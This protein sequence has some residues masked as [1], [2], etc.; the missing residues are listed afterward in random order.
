MPRTST[1]SSS[2]PE[3][4]PLGAPRG[5]A[6]LRE[7]LRA[8]GVV[9]SK[10]W[11]QSFLVDPF[12]ADM[13]TA[14]LEATAG[15]PI[16]EIGGGLGILTEAILRRG[17]GPITVVERDP[18]LARHLRE[19]ARGAFTVQLADALEVEFGGVRTVVGN[20]PFSVAAPILTRLFEA[21][22][23]RIVVL[24]QKEVGERYTAPAGGRRYGRP[25]IQAAL[26]GRAERFA[27]VPRSAFEPTPKVDGIL[28]R[29]SGRPGPLPVPSVTRFEAEVRQLF[30]SR[31]KQLGNL[32][33][34]LA[35]GTEG[36][37]RLADRAGWPEGWARRRPEELPP[38]SYFAL[39][40]ARA[41]PE[42][43]ASSEQ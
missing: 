38:E 32:L 22:V 14:L 9:P 30:A 27:T 39:S 13:E 20:L 4:A 36:A 19:M 42:E 37:R 34:A 18:R 33:P 23:G 40:R 8:L 5:A 28:V 43:P 16:V 1:G 25:A 11:G 24:L 31:R 6:E 15:E 41:R 26:Y 7:R 21:R 29:F 35:G 10:R 2:P 12:V 17:L 3:R